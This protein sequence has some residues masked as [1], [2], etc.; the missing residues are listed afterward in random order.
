MNSFVRDFAREKLCF[1]SSMFKGRSSAFEI[2]NH[3]IEKGCAG[4]ELM[5]FCDELCEPDMGIARELGE[6]AHK[7]RLRLPCFSVGMNLV[8]DGDGEMMKRAKGY[9]DICEMLEIPYFHHTV[10][11]R[12]SA[13]FEGEERAVCFR[14]GVEKSLEL[15]DYANA[16]GVKT[17]VEDQG[18]LF[19]GVKPFREFKQAMSD[20]IGVLLDVGN[21]YFVDETATDFARAF[22]SEIDHVHLKD[23][24]FTKEPPVGRGYYTSLCG[25]YI[26]GAKDGEG[27]IDFRSVAGVLR[28]AEYCGVYSLEFNLLTDDI[29]DHTFEYY[30]SVFGG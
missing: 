11:S 27:V 5:S 10:A 17:I 15:A 6:L 30:A 18:F 25:N 16:R 14:I 8:S 1:Y 7:N 26:Y 3:A 13:A 29:V 2:M 9:I 28:D 23:Y 24:Y 20:R 19:N 12:L 21:I 4:V 22:A